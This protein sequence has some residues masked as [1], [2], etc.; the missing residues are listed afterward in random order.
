MSDA[1]PTPT[2]FD[3]QP[4]VALPPD[5]SRRRLLQGALGLLSGAGL[6]GLGGCGGAA[7]EQ[8]ISLRVVN[9]TKISTAKLTVDGD[10]AVSA[11]ANGGTISSYISLTEGEHTFVMK[12][13]NDTL[14][15]SAT[16]NLTADTYYT[17]VGYGSAVSGSGTSFIKLEESTPAPSSSHVKVRLLHMSEN[18]E[19]GLALYTSSE[20][21]LSGESPICTVDSYR[22]QSDFEQIDKGAYRIRITR[23]DSPSV[24][25]FDLSAGINLNGGSCITLVV[26]PRSTDDYP[27][28][29]ALAEKSSNSMGLVNDLSV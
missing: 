4:A 2:R 21:S 12:S 22:G 16:Y 3:A 14:G 1:M 25:L 17:L 18:L 13:S 9:A 29:C 24:V 26:V 5:G 11:L 10:T 23:K 20:D 7:D 28:L 15:P 8:T 19:Y 6:M 27:D